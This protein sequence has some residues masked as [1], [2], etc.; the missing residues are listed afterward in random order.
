MSEVVK[1]Y[2]KIIDTVEVSLSEREE[3]INRR[4]NTVSPRKYH[5]TDNQ[6]YK[7]RE[8]WLLT[9]EGVSPDIRSMASDIFFNPYR[10]NGAYYGGVQSLYLLGS[11][12]WH[13]YSEVIKMMQSDMSTRKSATNKHN[14]W[15]KFSARSAREGAISTKDLL[16]RIVQN[17]RTV[18][19]LGGVH[20]YGYKLKQLN[21]TVDIRRLADGIWCFRL[22]TNSVTP[23]HDLSA[24]A[25]ANK[26]PKGQKVERKVIVSSE[27]VAV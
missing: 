1:E 25:D 24:Y 27:E 4:G 23:F 3:I 21:S 7:G 5:M 26:A 15:D 16:G 6:L 18:Q 13:N 17:F 12:E 11:N 22:N 8:R 2:D 14:S 10:A 9:L 19:R 20:P